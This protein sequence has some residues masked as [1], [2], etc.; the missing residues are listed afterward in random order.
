MKLSKWCFTFEKNGVTAIFHALTFFV[1]FIRTFEWDEFVEKFQEG[2]E[3]DREL[4]ELLLNNELIICCEQ[5]DDLLF[6]TVRDNLFNDD[7]VDL[8]YLLV[9]DGCNL[10]CKYCFE[11]SPLNTQTR[12]VFMN[13]ET[14][15]ESLNLFADVIDHQHNF[16]KNKIIHIYGGEPL[17]NKS[18][19]YEIIAYVQELKNIGRLPIDCLI[20]I[21]TNGVLLLEDDARFFGKNNVIVG[22]SVDGPKEI[23]NKYRIP[24]KYGLDVT[25]SIMNAYHLLKKYDVK[26]GLSVTITP[27]AV[28]NPSDFVNFFLGVDFKN[29]D[30]LSLNILHF[31]P[32]MIIDSDYYKMA[33]Q[34]QI[35]AFE[36]FREIGLY[37]ERVMRKIESFTSHKPMYADCGVV[38]NQLV[39]A[40]DGLI[41]VC[42]DFIKPRTYFSKSV[43]DYKISYDIPKLLAELFVEWRFR[44]PFFMEQC[45]RCSAIGICGGGCGASVELKTGNRFELDERACYHSLGILEWMIWDIYSRLD[46]C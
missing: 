5:A 26:V 36:Q 1:A 41:G 30:G 3:Y 4:F 18:A 6:N 8:L 19:V 42:Q 25:E 22:L 46:F 45:Q 2:G 16:H 34:C 17:A 27:D 23:T 40:P 28:I 13:K 32:N 24:K 11:D 10:K 33:V 39:I 35:K 21:V 43:F 20:V 37:E 38:G 7:S 44:S 14:V 31:S 29:L 15:R 12:A 9:T